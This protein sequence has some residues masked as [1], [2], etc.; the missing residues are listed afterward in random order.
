MA[1][2]RTHTLSVF[3]STCPP[4]LWAPRVIEWTE[5]AEQSARLAVRPATDNAESIRGSVTESWAEISFGHSHQARLCSSGAWWRPE[6]QAPGGRPSRE[7]AGRLPSRVRQQCKQ[8]QQRP[9]PWPAPSTVLLGSA[10]PVRPWGRLWP[11]AAPRSYRQLFHPVSL[12]S[13]K[14]PGK[15]SEAAD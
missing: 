2:T 6:E 4:L 1:A 10:A 5:A 9:R 12:G 3:T 7:G 8:Q 14:G 15:V 13:R 11:L